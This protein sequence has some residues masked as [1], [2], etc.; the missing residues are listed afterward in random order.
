[1]QRDDGMFAL[2]WHDDAAGPFAS[3]EFAAAVAAKGEGREWP[4]IATAAALISAVTIII[5]IA[6]DPGF[7]LEDWQTLMAACVALVGGTM[8][9]RG[10]MAKVILHDAQI[11]RL[12]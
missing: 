8:P 7:Q 11:A 6:R 5:A 9:Y 10:A 12:A 2:G 4:G 1:M 3:R